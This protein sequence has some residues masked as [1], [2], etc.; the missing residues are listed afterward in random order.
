MKSVLGLAALVRIKNLGR[1]IGGES[2]FQ[3]V[4]AERYVHGIGQSP[5]QD[6]AAAPVHDGSQIQKAALLPDIRSSTLVGGI[7]GSCACA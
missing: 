7:F 1:A 4:D 3:S 5:A 6:F 2:L